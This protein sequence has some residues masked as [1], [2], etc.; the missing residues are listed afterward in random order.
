MPANDNDLLMETDDVQFAVVRL[1]C[2]TGLH[3]ENAGEKRRAGGCP[4]Q[5]GIYHGVKLLPRVGRDKA[6]I[7]KLVEPGEMVPERR[8]NFEEPVHFRTAGAKV[9]PGQA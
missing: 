6:G 5:S 2:G 3:H 1:G 8:I 4:E 7:P 9:L